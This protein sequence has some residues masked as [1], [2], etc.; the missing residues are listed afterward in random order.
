MVLLKF[1]NK[2]AALD[3]MNSE[4]YQPVK[5]RQENSSGTMVLLEGI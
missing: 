2:Q 1:P 3:W 4:E 5:I